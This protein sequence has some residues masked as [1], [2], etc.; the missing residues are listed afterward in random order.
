MKLEELKEIYPNFEYYQDTENN[1]YLFSMLT[2]KNAKLN[3]DTFQREV[4][5]SCPFEN[6]SIDDKLNDETFLDKLHEFFS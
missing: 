2:R 3:S 1:R 5:Y 6:I 4:D